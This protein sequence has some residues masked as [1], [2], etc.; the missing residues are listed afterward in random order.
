M[1]IISQTMADYLENEEKR[2]KKSNEGKMNLWDD[3]SVFC[4]ICG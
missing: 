4:Q 3:A 2:G 1:V